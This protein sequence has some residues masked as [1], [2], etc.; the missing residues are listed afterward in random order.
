MKTTVLESLFNKVAGLKLS[1]KYCKIFKNSFFHK[2]PPVAASEKSI[3]F[4]RK[5]QWR[6]RN[7][8]IFL[9]MLMPY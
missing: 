5:Y 1:C 3:N 4:S 2:T 9:I 6:K 7:G 8:F